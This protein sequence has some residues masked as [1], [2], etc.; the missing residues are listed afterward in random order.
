MEGRRARVSLSAIRVRHLGRGGE[1]LFSQVCPNRLYD[2]GEDIL[3]NESFRA[4][5]SFPTAWYGRLAGGTP[6]DTDT[7]AS[8][9]SEPLPT[10]TKGYMSIAWSRGTTHWGAITTLAGDRV[11][12]GTKFSFGPA[13]AVWSNLTYFFFATRSDN[14]GTK[15]FARFQLSQPRTVNPGETLDIQPIGVIRGL[16]S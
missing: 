8:V 2:E 4:V 11:V 13:I 15:L 12:Y 16:S 5:A 14:V 10:L 3:L 7:I 6:A 1:V 9:S